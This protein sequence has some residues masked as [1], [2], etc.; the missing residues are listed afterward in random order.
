MGTGSSG[1]L[2]MLAAF[3]ADLNPPL[4]A[5]VSFTIDCTLESLQAR[6]Y[7]LLCLRCSIEYCSYSAHTNL[8]TLMLRMSAYKHTQSEHVEPFIC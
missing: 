8:L 1:E 6:E 2:A 4:A 5:P 3:W 7:C